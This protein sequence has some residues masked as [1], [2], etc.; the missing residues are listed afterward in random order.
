MRI[1]NQGIDIVENA[2]DLPPALYGPI[3][4]TD[5]LGILRAGYSHKYETT[6]DVEDCN[7]SISMFQQPLGLIKEDNAEL[8]R[9]LHNLARQR[10]NKFQRLKQPEHLMNAIPKMI[11]SIVKHCSRKSKNSWQA[12]IAR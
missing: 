4:T 2:L 3:D 10:W 7:K 6:D 5:L 1:L 12:Q 8:P 9:Y 11:Q